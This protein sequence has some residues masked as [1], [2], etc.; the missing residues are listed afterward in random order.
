MSNAEVADRL[1]TLAHLLSTHKENPYKVKAYRR[2]SE[3]IR[4]MAESIDE[5][6][7]EETDLTQYEAIGPAISNAIREIVLTGSL[8]TLETLRSQAPAEVLELSSF[9][10]LDPNRVLRVYK[11]L[12]ISSVPELRER[13]AAGEIGRRMGSRME[14]HIRQGLHPSHSMLL[15]KADQLRVTVE[16]FLL[17]QCRV[18]RAEAVGDYRRRLEVIDELSFVIETADLPGVTGKLQ[19]YGGET[20]LLEERHRTVEFALPSG[21]RLKIEAAAADEWGSA[22]VRTTGSE[23]HLQKLGPPGT[24]ATET[25]VYASAG[26]SYIE[27]EL[28]EGHD[29]ID[30]AR[31]GTLPALVTVADIRGELHAH[32]TASDGAHS[33]EQMAQAAKEKGYE[34]IGITDHSQSLKIARGVS[35]EDL[36]KQIRFIDKLQSKL[37]LRVLK[38]AEVDILA[39]GSLDYPDDLL[40]ELDYT[41]CSIHSRFNLGQAE[42]TERILRAMDNRHF[43]ILGH[44]TGRVLLTRPGYEIDV[45]RIV[46]HARSRGCFFEINSSPNRLDLRAEH[47]RVATAAGVRIAVNTDAHSTREL[48]LVR[49]GIDQA[50]RAGLTKEAVLNCLPLPELLRLLKR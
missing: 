3:R 48:D 13:L 12:G 19:R 1:A 4:G 45:P 10:R 21:L 16:G 36:W 14:Q 50:R 24:H 5:L 20:V 37:P 17:D 2:A 49:Y 15:Y 26:L 9:P 42:Q 43:T 8:R 25:G 34:Y 11:K 7:H 30:H 47:A 29:E 6:V 33:I 46:A 31:R 44:A 35:V 22:L 28:R 38:S 41:V 18:R 40:A 39:D 32:S 27:P 23:A